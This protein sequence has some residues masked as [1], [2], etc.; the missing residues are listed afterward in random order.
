MM[1]P[2]DIWG[3]CPY[4]ELLISRGR[5]QHK[6]FVCYIC[7]KADTICDPNYCLGPDEEVDDDSKGEAHEQEIN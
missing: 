4:R 7:T 3:R 2:G 1:R 6:H 5:G